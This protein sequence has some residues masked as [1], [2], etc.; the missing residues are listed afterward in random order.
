MI[1]LQIE[2]A[3]VSDVWCRRCG[4]FGQGSSPVLRSFFRVKLLQRNGGKMGEGRGKA[5]KFL[6]RTSWPWFGWV[7]W[8]VFAQLIAIGESCQVVCAWIL[9]LG[10]VN[11][12]RLFRSLFTSLR[13]EACNCNS[14][15]VSERSRLSQVW[16]RIN[17]GLMNDEI[18]KFDYSKLTV[19]FLSVSDASSY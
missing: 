11:W 6:T 16:D 12:Y 1:L 2:A 5:A 8:R 15:H 18:A 14:M 3:T 9:S 19:R 10:K 13:S 7:W 4:N 17:Y